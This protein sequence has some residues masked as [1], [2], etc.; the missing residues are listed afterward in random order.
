MDWGGENEGCLKPETRNPKPET[1]NP[2]PETRNPKPRMNATSTP[3]ESGAAPADAE[4]YVPYQDEAGFGLRGMVILLV[5]IAVSGIAVF[6]AT[7]QFSGL[8]AAD[9][10]DAG[11]DATGADSAAVQ[12]A[13]PS[14]DD[15]AA[16]SVGYRIPIERAMELVAEEAARRQ[17]RPAEA[18]P[19][20]LRTGPG[21]R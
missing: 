6:F 20:P 1:R 17:G 16:D 7:A 5:A 10:A 15:Y 2:K 9:A 4:P 21:E 14:L 13:A 11:A 19:F 12:A 3:P 8:G 18:A